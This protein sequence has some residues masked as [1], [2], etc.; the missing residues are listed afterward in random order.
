MSDPRF[1]DP[2]N[3]DPR[4]SDP[5]LRQD[6]P[7]GGIWGWVAGLAVLALIAFIV[8]AGWNSDHNTA[9]NAPPPVTTGANS[10]GSAPRNAM[11]PSTTG[12]G[13]SSPMAPTPSTPAPSQS[14]NGSR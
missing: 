14:P 2:R 11:P 10:P 3:S 12:S 8:V 4:L 1:T 13:A 6:E 9:S 5:V 7:A